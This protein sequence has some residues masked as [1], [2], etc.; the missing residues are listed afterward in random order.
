[1]SIFFIDVRDRKKAMIEAIDRFTESSKEW[2][3]GNKDEDLVA[4]SIRRS[5]LR[6]AIEK[7]GSFLSD[8]VIL[9]GQVTMLCVARNQARAKKLIGV[10]ADFIPRWW[11]VIP[12]KI[13]LWPF[14]LIYRIIKLG[15]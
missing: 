7:E 12:L 8:E 10:I 1:M 2:S 5:E 6:E 9:S 4:Y 15:V 3:S 11:W 13:L 14:I